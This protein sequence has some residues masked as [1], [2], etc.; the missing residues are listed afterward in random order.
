MYYAQK[1]KIGGLIEVVLIEDAILNATETK[2]RGRSFPSGAGKR[3][4]TQQQGF[5]A[6]T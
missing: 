4:L 5:F 3:K 6:D 1:D 2:T